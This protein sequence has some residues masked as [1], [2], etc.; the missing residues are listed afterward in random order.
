MPTSPSRPCSRHHAVPRLET[1]D[2]C[3]PHGHELI[4]NNCFNC[5]VVRGAPGI[6]L[7]APR[8]TDLKLVYDRT[9]VDSWEALRWPDDIVGTVDQLVIALDQHGLRLKAGDLVLTGAWGASIQVADHTQE[10]VTSDAFGNVS[11]TFS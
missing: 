5:G 1:G 2:V 3:R 4:A 7:G 8:Q 9:A 10:D 11:T 6:D